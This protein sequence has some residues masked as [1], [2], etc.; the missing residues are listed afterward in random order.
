MSAEASEDEQAL[1]AILRD[2]VEDEYP[3]LCTAIYFSPTMQK[4]LALLLMRAYQIG[5]EVGR[6]K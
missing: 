1:L 2:G 3:A 4:E 6:R 5:K